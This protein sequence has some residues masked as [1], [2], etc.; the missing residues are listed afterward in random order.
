MD[1]K[2]NLFSSWLRAAGHQQWLAS[3]MRRQLIVGSIMVVAQHAVL[4]DLHGG[5]AIDI[6]DIGQQM[7]EQL[8]AGAPGKQLDAGQRR[9][10]DLL[11]N[12]A[13][14]DSGNKR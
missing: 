5:R 1:N 3:D 12:Q 2:N 8:G 6:V 14:N 11:L 9:L 7:F 13:E 4:E 10:A